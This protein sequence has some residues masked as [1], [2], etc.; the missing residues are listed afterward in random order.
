MNVIYLKAGETAV[1]SAR[2]GVS[3]KVPLLDSN[4][5]AVLDIQREVHLAGSKRNCD[6]DPDY[7]LKNYNRKRYSR[8]VGHCQV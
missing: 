3:V 1:S 6:N 5:R 8:L 7:Y 2:L 4:M